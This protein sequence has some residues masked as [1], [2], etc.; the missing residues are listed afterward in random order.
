MFKQNQ[1][2]ISFQPVFRS[3]GLWLGNSQSIKNKPTLFP[4]LKLKESPINLPLRP[5]W[6]WG[7]DSKSKW[8][9]KVSVRLNKCL[10]SFP[11]FPTQSFI[12]NIIFPIFSVFSLTEK[13]SGQRNCR[14]LPFWPWYGNPSTAQGPSSS[15]WPSHEMHFPSILPAAL[16]HVTFP[17]MPHPYPRDS[18]F[19]SHRQDNHKTEIL[20]QWH[21]WSCVG[22][23][24]GKETGWTP[25]EGKAERGKRV[26]VS[27][28]INKNNI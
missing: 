27:L 2:K 9:V 24:C 12:Q 8:N 25:E 20:H 6:V 4:T 19:L 14:Q 5:F 3:G 22:L 1:F 17:S 7:N 16:Q 23:G 10:I 13:F 11:I 18:A 21:L 28:Q 26:G 15:L